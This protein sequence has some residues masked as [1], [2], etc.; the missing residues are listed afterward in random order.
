MIID[1]LDNSH[2]YT[3]INP[4]IE[5]G[6]KYIKSTNFNL[7]AEGF[8]D[9]KD[10]IFAIV[11]EYHSKEKLECKPEA[12]RKYIDIQYIIQ[13]K[14]FI[15]YTPLVKQEVL[16][17][18]NSDQ[19]VIFYKATCSFSEITQGMFAIYFPTDIHQPCVKVD[20]SI[21][22]KKVVVKIPV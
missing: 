18:Y 13:G 2:L 21:A 16:I 17:D 20:E 8:Y 15:G 3:S 9:I 12:H 22:I 7:L 1:R 4:K 14:E 19:D 6:L 10:G 5:I 11:S